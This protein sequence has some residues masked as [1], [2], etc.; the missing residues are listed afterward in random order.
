MTG[1]SRVSN[2]A[3]PAPQRSIASAYLRP[4]VLADVL[5]GMFELFTAN[6]RVYVVALG[7]LLIPI[8]FA[9]AYLTSEVYGGTGL[10]EQ[11]SNPAAAE[12]FFAGGPNLGPFLGLLAV[13]IASFVLVTPF[14]N[15]VACRIAAEG[16]GHRRPAIGEVLRATL[17]HYAALVGVTLLLTLIV[18]ALL[19]LPVLLVVGAVA[20]ESAGLGVAAVVLMIAAGV[21]AAF[22]FVRASL[23]YPVVVVEGA[24]ALTAL[25]RSFRLVRGRFWRVLLTLMLAGFISTIVAYVLSL[26]FAV[27]GELFGDWAGVVFSTAG[28]VVAAVLTTPLVANAQTLLYFDGRVRIEGYDLDVLSRTVASD[29][30]QPLG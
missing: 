12:A 23:S 10:L 6:W 13:G 19:A 25:R 11:F 16:Y 18:V 24:G 9:V 5:D 27:P 4:L 7:L 17:R 21:G 14:V 2:D 8:N 26:P 22:L 20:T 29:T 3:E 1:G 30:G 28:G 15:G